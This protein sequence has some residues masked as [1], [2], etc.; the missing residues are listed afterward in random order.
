MRSLILITY[1]VMAGWL[2]ISAALRVMLL[3]G[4]H[5]PLDPLPFISGGIALVALSTARRVLAR[6]SD[7]GAGR[8]ASHAREQDP[9][10]R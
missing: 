3:L 7:Q 9:G 5:L 6:D 4:N 1:V 2:L 8:D 10:P